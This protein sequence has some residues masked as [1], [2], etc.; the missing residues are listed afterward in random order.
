MTQLPP[1][2][3]DK[4]PILAEHEAIHD[5]EP[6]F[7]WIWSEARGRP[8]PHSPQPGDRRASAKAINR[9]ITGLPTVTP[10]G[11]R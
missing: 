5:G 11:E 1:T 4:G 8:D 3:A 6:I 7:G 10:E 2:A 9:N